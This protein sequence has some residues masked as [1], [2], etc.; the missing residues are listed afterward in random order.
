MSVPL[1]SVRLRPTLL[2]FVL[3][4][5]ASWPGVGGA[6][7]QLCARAA[8][9][10]GNTPVTIFAITGDA[11]VL[12]KDGA[13][14]WRLLWSAP[15]AG[16]SNLIALAA[17][18]DGRTLY[19]YPSIRGDLWRSADAGAHWTNI[20]RGRLHAIHVDGLFMTLDQRHADTLYV[21]GQGGVAKTANGGASW[22]RVGTG[23]PTVDDV[24]VLRVDSRFSARLWAGTY[25]HGSY[26]SDD[27]GRT[28][29]AIQGLPDS[30]RL[31]VRD[32][33]IAPAGGG[34][35]YLSTDSALYRSVDDGQRWTTLAVP[36]P[37]T[38]KK[39]LYVGLAISPAQPTRIYAQTQ[40]AGTY[41]S[42][43]AGR[44]WRLLTALPDAAS[45]PLADPVD[46][47]KSYVVG[48]DDAYVTADGGATWH[49]LGGGNLSSSSGAYI[50]D[51]AVSE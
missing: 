35:V 43:D 44:T 48:G 17:A 4:V 9:A 23:L 51:L 38:V 18:T 24:D 5:L 2:A 49:D 16:N 39:P 8:S 19:A 10:T 20:D 33:A 1:Q 27:G 31:A 26:R 46:P 30:D 37:R 7:S 25:H 47:L 41:T 29:R 13:A 21:Y 32:I 50:V 15:E 11:T 34:A 6:T 40:Y 36:V 3:A 14:R 28:W 42:T 45:V 22:T 12:R